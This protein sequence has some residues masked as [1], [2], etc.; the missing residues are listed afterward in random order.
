[1]S[2]K[3]KSDFIEKNLDFLKG[4]GDTNKGIEALKYIEVIKKYLSEIEGSQD[5]IE[6]KFFSTFYS[7]LFQLNSKALLIVDKDSR[8]KIKELFRERIK[9]YIF[10]SPLCR[11]GYTKPKGYPGDYKIIEAIYNGQPIAS[12]NTIGFL[13]DQFF[14]QEEYVQAVRD[15]KD[16]MKKIFK[17]FIIQHKSKKM[18]ILNI[19]CGSCREIRELL[20]EDFSTR[21]AV[22][23]VLIDQDK[24]CLDYSKKHLSGCPANYKFHFLQSNVFSFFRNGEFEKKFGKFDLIYS[25]GLADYLSDIILGDM[26]QKGF[27]R[28]TMDGKFIIAHK[29]VKKFDS[30]SS[31]W[32]C[33]W[34]FIPRDK[35]DI[36]GL[37]NRYLV[38][39][40]YNIRY[41]Y[42]KSK[43][44]FFFTLENAAKPC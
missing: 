39:N 9:K 12:K 8:A 29:N 21:K 2:L 18:K 16:M 28:L 11:H 13:F 30:I 33:D 42:L 25:I 17:S 32:V 41:E 43:L 20:N 38:P 10:K 15:R 24:E 35:N 22:D 37:I 19:A 34:S 36:K 3:I 1:M 7:H 44:I 6:D 26:I 40:T 5:K 14:L 4:S 23:F 31:D 27:G